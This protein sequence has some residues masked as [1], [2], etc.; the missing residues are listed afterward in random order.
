MTSEVLLSWV[1]CLKTAPSS[2]SRAP[3]LN[4]ATHYPEKIQNDAT[5]SLQDVHVHCSQTLILCH[6]FRFDGTADLAM[7]ETILK[8]VKLYK[9][10]PIL[11]VMMLALFVFLCPVVSQTC[12]F[13]NLFT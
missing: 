5:P 9:R 13:P 3:C 8:F 12:R 11:V 2:G 1:G 10:Q 7:L 6:G 4:D